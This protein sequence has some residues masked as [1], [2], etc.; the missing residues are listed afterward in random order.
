VLC[1]FTPQLSLVQWDYPTPGGY[2]TLSTYLNDDYT[3]LIRSRLRL[4][5]S[6]THLMWLGSSQLLD[7]IDIGVVPV[8]SARVTVC[9]TVRDLG[10][11]LAADS[12]WPIMTRQSVA[13]VTI[14][15]RRCVQSLDR[16]QRR[17]SRQWWST[18]SFRPA[19]NTVIPY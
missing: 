7:K 5:A 2:S 6:K 18:R 17:Q 14:S 3:W 9:D 10:V 16:S 11:I 13:P 19:W 12:P 4:N 15:C 1:P 8:V